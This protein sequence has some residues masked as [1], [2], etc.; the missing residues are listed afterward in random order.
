MLTIS[1]LSKCED[2]EFSSN[3]VELVVWSLH[4][5]YDSLDSSSTFCYRQQFC[6][7]NLFLL[8]SIETC[9]N[10]SYRTKPDQLQ[11][12][13]ESGYKPSIRHMNFSSYLHAFADMYLKACCFPTNYFYLKQWKSISYWQCTVVKLHHC[14]FL[15]ALLKKFRGDVE[16]TVMII[17]V[18][19]FFIKPEN[20]YYFKIKSISCFLTKKFVFS[21]KK[22][23]LSP[24]IM[25]LIYCCKM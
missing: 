20:N 5:E 18:F 24:E 16:K 25:I 2:A 4:T 6:I 14:L 9:E 21:I 22:C 1:V 23:N 11:S 15:R 3:I 12:L 13:F 17:D 19:S 7:R 8:S 10:Q